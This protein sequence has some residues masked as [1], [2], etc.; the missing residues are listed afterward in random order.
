MASFSNLL[1]EEPNIARQPSV[2]PSAAAT[3]KSLGKHFRKDVPDGGFYRLERFWDGS[4]AKRF[5]QPSFGEP[6][7]RF[8]L[9]PPSRHLGIRSACRHTQR[10]LQRAQKHSTFAQ[11]ACLLRPQLPHPFH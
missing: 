8:R 6:G 7:E 10:V 1:D 2:A 4:A 5:R 11:H 9:L 3:L